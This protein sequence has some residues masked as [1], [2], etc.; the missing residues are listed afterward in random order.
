MRIMPADFKPKLGVP[1]PDI[2]C[3]KCGKPMCVREAKATRHRFLSCTNYP[4]CQH[5]EDYEI[6]NPDQLQMF[7]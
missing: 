6:E 2:R 7:I 1:L 4:I 3:P 5:A